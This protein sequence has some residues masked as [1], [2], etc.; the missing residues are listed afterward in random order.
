MDFAA[1]SNEM[2]QRRKNVSAKDQK[3]VRTLPWMPNGIVRLLT[4][5]LICNILLDPFDKSLKDLHM[6]LERCLLPVYSTR[7]NQP[8]V[9]QIVQQKHS[10][11]HGRTECLLPG[12]LGL[13]PVASYLCSSSTSV[14]IV[15]GDVGSKLSHDSMGMGTHTRPTNDNLW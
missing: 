3:G 4:S 7:F 14:R 10:P 2:M 9:L 6:F 13:S 12:T 5:L 1:S 11:L 15:G 8:L